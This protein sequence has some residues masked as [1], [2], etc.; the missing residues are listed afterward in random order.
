MNIDQVYKQVVE[1]VL[2]EGVKKANRTAT[3][4][5]S[6]SG[7]MIEY[8]MANG[9]PL[10]TT[11]KMAWKTI[12]VEL[13]G[14]I[15]RVTDKSWFQER[16]FKLGVISN[17]E[18]QIK[19]LVKHAQLDEKFE[20]VIDSGEIGI[21]KPDEGIFRAA[22]EGMGSTGEKSIYVG[23]QYRIDVLGARNAGITPILVER[24]YNADERDCI[25]VPRV[26]DLPKLEIF[27]G[28]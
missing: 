7:C 20:V 24:A 22:L 21:T 25:T 3:D 28:I 9:F 2:R 11:K 17:A 23:D 15:K 14:F 13:E 19:R 12:R 4:A 16:G 6:V 10:L 8:D 26:T 1:K 18:G 5:I 27:Q